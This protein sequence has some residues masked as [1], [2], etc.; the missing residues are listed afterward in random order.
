MAYLGPTVFQRNTSMAFLRKCWSVPAG[1]TTAYT[2]ACTTT[3]LHHRSASISTLDLISRVLRDSL[4]PRSNSL[5]YL[6]DSCGSQ[7]CARAGG[8]WDDS[9]MGSASGGRCLNSWQARRRLKD[10]SGAYEEIVVQLSFDEHIT[11]M[12]TKVTES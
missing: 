2:S 11:G 4:A 5:Q 8:V 3:R 6:D 7:R 12:L 1:S 10:A 9:E